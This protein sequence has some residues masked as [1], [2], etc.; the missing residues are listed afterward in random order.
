MF[1]TDIITKIQNHNLPSDA[2]RGVYGANE[3]LQRDITSI[4]TLLD[5]I[6]PKVG[7]IGL[8][9]S[10]DT[11][12]SSFL[13][14]FAVSVCLGE[15]NFLGF[16][17][18]P[19]HRRAIYVS[20][21]DDDFAVSYLLNRINNEKKLIPEQYRGLQFVFDTSNLLQT[22]EHLLI[23]EPTDLI[24]IDAFADLYGRSMNDANQVRTFLNEYSQLAQRHK[25]LIIFLHHT[26]KR[27]EDLAPSKHNLLGSQGFEA[28]MRL[29]I[30]LRTDQNEPDKRHLCIVKGNY[31]PKEFKTESFVL[32]FNDNLIFENT[33]QRRV[34]EDLTP[35][36]KSEL[37]NE[38]KKLNIDGLT[39]TDIAKKL[40][41]SQATVSRFMKG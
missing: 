21:E 41:I 25:C 27:T 34:F 26:G 6:F 30:E 9:G 17:L 10:S 1:E 8:A 14:Q 15:S 5:P 29:V 11:G 28:K 33:H 18:K 3:L 38:V 13:R 2:F 24:I 37:K 32:S 19:T 20:T 16:E 7:L 12:K 31:L 40:K 4:P 23:D 36:N 35:S 39:Q 22:I